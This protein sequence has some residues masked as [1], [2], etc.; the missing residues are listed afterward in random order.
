MIYAIYVR[1]SDTCG[2][3]EFYGP[4]GYIEAESLKEAEKLF[5]FGAFVGYS[6]K[7]IEIVDKKELKKKLEKAIDDR[8]YR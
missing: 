8:R 3:S 6:I 4:E 2:N 7:E 1:C 5:P